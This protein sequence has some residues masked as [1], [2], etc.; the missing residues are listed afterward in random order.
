MSELAKAVIGLNN[1]ALTHFLNGDFDQAIELL[2]TAY[3]AFDRYKWQVAL[4]SCNHQVYSNAV[5]APS[6]RP[7]D[8]TKDASF[9]DGHHSFQS[10]PGFSAFFQSSDIFA[11]GIA[12]T[13]TLTTM[14]CASDSSPVQRIAKQGHF[15][16]ASGC[17]SCSLVF[18]PSTA[19]SM[20]NR[21][22]V[23][24]IDQ[25]DFTLMILHRHRTE[26]VIMYNLALV[27]HNIGIHLGISSALP[28]ALRLYELALTSIDQRTNIL[29]VQK[30]LMAI[31]NNLGNIYTHFYCVEE[32]E[33]CME[34]LRIV[35]AASSCDRT[36]DED[37][38]FFLLNALFQIKELSFA[39]AA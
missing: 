25:D 1:G 26:A 34:N 7:I 36:V 18:S 27:Y 17:S 6:S 35:L 12:T 32:T 10:S 8:P 38:S 24:S 19:H 16:R 3:A 13:A 21:A 31:L 20:Y 14:D 5:D 37:Y 23:L 9:A 33:R 29:E 15:S 4:M 30:L 22:L 2:G 39:P 11:P 28:H